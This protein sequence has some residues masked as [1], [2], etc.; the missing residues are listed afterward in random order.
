MRVFFRP[1]QW[2]FVFSILLKTSFLFAEQSE[3]E[4]DQLLLDD[5]RSEKIALESVLE[6]LDHQ[7]EP[8][9]WMHSYWKWQRS[10]AELGEPLDVDGLMEF[11]K[12]AR[13][14][15]LTDIAWDLERLYL[16]TR[17]ATNL[18]QQIK[19]TQ[20]ILDYIQRL[21]STENPK[22]KANALL[23]LGL[24]YDAIG[25]AP[26]AMQAYQ[27]AMNLLRDQP[28]ASALTRMN[29]MSSIS[30]NLYNDGK[31]E[32][33]EDIKKQIL[34]L[35]KQ[36]LWR[37]FCADAAYNLGSILAS[38]HD[39]EKIRQAAPY[40]FRTEE[41]AKDLQSPLYLARFDYGMMKYYAALDQNQLAQAHG[42]KALE[43]FRALADRAF[44]SA[45]L[46]RLARIYEK[47]HKN[48]L[49]LR[50]AREAIDSLHDRDFGRR[51]DMLYLVYTL[52]KNQGHLTEALLVLEE[53][54]ATIAKLSQ[55]KDQTNYN[56]L[57]V[58]LGL[59]FE[60]EKS[61]I[62][63]S[64]LKL[65]NILRQVFF[66]L[67]FISLIT[68]VLF[69]KFFHQYRQIQRLRRAEKDIKNQE[70]SN[71]ILHLE[72]GL[73]LN[74]ASAVAHR[75][76]NPLNHMSLA[77]EQVHSNQKRLEETVS[78]LFI[79]A[80]DDDP[81]IQNIKKHFHDI[82]QD[83]HSHSG[84]IQASIQNTRQAVSELRILS[85]ID[86]YQQET[87]ALEQVIQDTQRRLEELLNAAQFSRIEMRLPERPEVCMLLGNK[88][89]L[90]NA[91]ELLLLSFVK[92]GEGSV[93]AIFE[94][95]DSKHL[96]VRCDLG[97]TP[98]PIL[99]EALELSLGNVLKQALVK[100]TKVD[101]YTFA[102]SH[103][104]ESQS[105]QIAA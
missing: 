104:G 71:K 70:R 92:E 103:V 59:T 55:L 53:Y 26:L 45:T 78:A 49:A 90:K 30:V 1:S 79:T 4:W 77:L 94:W 80:S 35:C 47:Q 18:E 86:G 15:N 28:Q 40:F 38:S 61:K 7:R 81:E 37:N 93:C 82:F 39:I 10:L 84:I 63:A 25:K 95:T 60:E 91:L 72:T 43:H 13:K 89:V 69:Y 85:G 64:E 29:L 54:T 67:F 12:E 98:N 73:R 58:D 5:P 21:E 23:S 42:E 46:E 33:A 8:N 87:F 74:L 66:G 75:V 51:K 44:T 24:H 17:P 52:E 16:D 36:H 76:N 19:K 62:L 83:F 57:A 9:L 105:L 11:A 31:V 41:L 6:N 56:K 3:A 96:Q 88:F 48:D 68:L 14:Q 2:I 102:F 100:V 34:D 97:F 101:L 20:D 27:K 50:Y 22:L 65:Q 32:K 99:W